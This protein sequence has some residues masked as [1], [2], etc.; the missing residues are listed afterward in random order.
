MNFTF[1][2]PPTTNSAYAN[3]QTGGR[4]LT[5]EA[6]AWKEEAGWIVKSSGRSFDLAAKYKLFIALYVNRDRDIDGSLK[7]LLDAMS[8]VVYD[9]DAQVVV[10][11]VY[12][13]LKHP[14]EEP[15]VE[16]EITELAETAH[17]GTAPHFPGT[18][19]KRRTTR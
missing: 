14:G 2:L 13:F 18:I 6:R 1:S 16:V 10:L 3:R 7:L 11:V 5:Q 9:D 4:I 8:G 17:T 12:K 15:R 19:K